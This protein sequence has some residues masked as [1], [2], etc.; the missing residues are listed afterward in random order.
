MSEYYVTIDGERI[1]GPFEDRASAK[2]VADDLN[3]HDV[4]ARYRIRKA[5]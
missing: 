4:G 2:R 3:T 5:G 1:E